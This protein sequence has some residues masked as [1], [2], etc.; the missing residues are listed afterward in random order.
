MMISGQLR[1]DFVV[2]RSDLYYLEVGKMLAL[3]PFIMAVGYPVHDWNFFVKAIEMGYIYARGILIGMVW[4]FW[5]HSFQSIVIF[6]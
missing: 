2:F 3:Y 1:L 5:D 4:H 6:H